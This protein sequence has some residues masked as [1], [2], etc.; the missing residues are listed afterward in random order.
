MSQNAIVQQENAI[1][2]ASAGAEA[3]KKQIDS[4]STE[5]ESLKQENAELKIA[6]ERLENSIKNRIKELERKVK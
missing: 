3:L 2:L 4:M 5:K 6:V 1:E